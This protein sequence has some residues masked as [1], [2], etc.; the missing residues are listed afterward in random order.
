[1]QNKGG[2]RD[3]LSPRGPL[4]SQVPQMKTSMTLDL[5]S[6]SPRNHF[7]YPQFPACH[8]EMEYCHIPLSVVPLPLRPRNS[9]PTTWTFSSAA[10]GPFRTSVSP[11]YMGQVRTRILTELQPEA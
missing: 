4:V 6:P 7:P 2:F 8:G 11:F 3:S 1:M 5:T 10:R 9:S